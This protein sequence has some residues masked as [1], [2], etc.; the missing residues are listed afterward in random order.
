MK[1]T[2]LLVLA[3]MATAALVLASA[4]VAQADDV[5]CPPALVGAQV[6]GNVVV[7]AGQTC[8]ITNS[9]IRGNV[10]VRSGA[11][12]SFFSS[13]VH[14]NIEGDGF[15]QI[16]VNFSTVLILGEGVVGNVIAKNGSNPGRVQIRDSS[17]NGSAQLENNAGQVEIIN[18]SF[19]NP[20]TNLCCGNIQVVKSTTTNTMTI[21]GN[22][23]SDIQF[24]EN[25]A[26]AYR[27]RGN[28]DVRGNVQVYKNVHTTASGG[29]VSFN[30]GQNVQCFEN[31]GPGFVGGPNSATKAEGQCF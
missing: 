9:E 27:I 10:I 19:G 29:E 20:I 23:A 15:S 14:G 28:F 2:W 8:I 25:R 7:P 18:N 26:S 22:R 13:L 30:D 11:T 12:L 31:M 4:P 16:F 1:R 17:I 21:D 3:L 24:Y 5:N 6:N